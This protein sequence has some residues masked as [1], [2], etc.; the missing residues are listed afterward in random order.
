MNGSVN[1][2][3]P[4]FSSDRKMKE[5]EEGEGKRLIECL[6]GRLLAERQ[7]S[8][9]ATEEAVLMGKRVPVTRLSSL[10][11]CDSTESRRFYIASAGS[12]FILL[13][14]IC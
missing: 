13:A 5:G 1:A 11:H 7:A 3:Y 6:R 4:A 9:A 8:R 10:L 14:F 2:L 12:K